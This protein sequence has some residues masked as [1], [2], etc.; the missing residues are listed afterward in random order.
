M[1]TRLR[2]HLDRKLQHR[3]T[4]EELVERNILKA[5]TGKVSGSLQAQQQQLKK[6]QVLDGL[7]KRLSSRPTI[8]Q[9]QQQH[10]LDEGLIYAN[11]RFL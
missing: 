5:N 3:P 9:L 2:D 8:L 7:S 6:Q 11:L 4:S 1:H 10:I